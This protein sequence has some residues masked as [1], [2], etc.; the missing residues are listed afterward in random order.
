MP[1]AL[2]HTCLPAIVDGKEQRLAKHRLEAAKLD[3][4]AVA[5]GRIIPQ[6]A[7]AGLIVGLQECSNGMGEGSQEM[8]HTYTHTHTC[9][10]RML[11]YPEEKRGEGVS[12]GHAVATK[13]PPPKMRWGRGATP[14]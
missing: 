12:P 8:P 9:A 13:H 3:L 11:K 5:I 2:Q 7:A 4:I 10:E 14:C 1:S 6:V